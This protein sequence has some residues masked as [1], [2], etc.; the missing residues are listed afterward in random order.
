MD[1]PAMFENIPPKAMTYLATQTGEGETVLWVGTTAVEVRRR[2]LIPMI[3]GCL[4]MLLLCSWVFSM[5]NPSPWGAIGLSALVW[6][7]IPVVVVWRQ[8]DHLRR[9]LYAITDRRALV[10]S[11]D[12]PE[13]TEAYPPEKVE[14]IKVTMKK[15]GRGDVLFLTLRGRR[16]GPAAH[17]TYDHGFLDVLEPHQV[18]AIM[19]R[20]FPDAPTKR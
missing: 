17:V 8:S 1:K 16:T 11:V 13:K 5:N 9:T 3:M 2:R 15:T 18:A 14:F 10:L 6:V 12:K 4:F 20:S 7:G 19:R